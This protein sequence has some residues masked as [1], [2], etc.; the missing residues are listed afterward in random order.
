MTTTL[1]SSRD[2]AVMLG[3][4]ESTVKRWS[5]EGWISC[6]KTP[7]GH[8]KYRMSDVAEFAR[9]RGY[10]PVGLELSSFNADESMRIRLAAMERRFDTL[11]VIYR[12]VAL[13]GEGE[14]LADLAGHLYAAGISFAEICDRI[15]GPSMRRI[16]GEWEKGELEVNREHAASHATIEMLNRLRPS[17][18]ALPARGTAVCG[19]LPGELHDIPLLCVRMALEMEGWRT[20]YVGGNIPAASLA[21]A[22]RAHNPGIVCLSAT[23]PR[24]REELAAAVEEIRRASAGRSYELILGGSAV[25][26]EAL[27]GIRDARYVPDIGKLVA[28]LQSIRGTP[29]IA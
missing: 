5:D 13:G 17:L 4:N 16:G 19:T 1:Y 26:P 15:V 23:L 21:D 12:E 25:T 22:I 28:H 10:K 3:V 6:F 7:G 9:A 8:R 29:G 14:R 11:A 2:V 24:T 20:Y 27:S 18:R